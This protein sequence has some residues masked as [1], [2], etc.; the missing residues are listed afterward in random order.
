MKDQ[1]NEQINYDSGI[2]EDTGA[3]VRSVS[4]ALLAVAFSVTMDYATAVY[5]YL[6]HPV[7][8][9]QVRV[10]IMLLFSLSLF[11]AVILVKKRR[12]AIAMRIAIGWV[13]LGGL[14]HT[15]LFQN[16]GHAALLLV[17]T[18]TAAL[19]LFVFSTQNAVKLVASSAV[20]GILCLLYDFFGPSAYRLDEPSISTVSTL[21]GGALFAILFYFILINLNTLD[22]LK[23]TIEERTLALIQTNKFND[24]L[25]AEINERKKIEEELQLAKVAAEAASEAKSEFLATMSHEIRTPMNGVIG[26]TSLL[27]DTPLD[28]EQEDYVET[29]RMSGSALLGII[30]EILDF[31]KIESGNLELEYQRFD[32]YNCIEE[33]IDLLAFSASEKGLEIGYCLD[34]YVPQYIF[35]DVTRLRQILVNLIGNAVKF[36]HKGHVLVEVK[37]EHSEEEIGSKMLHFTVE[38]TGIG[39]SENQMPRLFKSFSQVDASTSRKYGG[40]GLGLAISKQL[41]EMMGGAMWVESAGEGL[42]A[43]FHFLIEY[44]RECDQLDINPNDLQQKIAKLKNRRLLIIDD[45]YL[46]REIIGRYCKAWGMCWISVPVVSEAVSLLESGEDFDFIL[47]ASHVH[48]GEVV[49]LREWNNSGKHIP[50]LAL[51][52]IGENLETSKGAS[53]EAHL[54]KPIRISALL[55]VLTNALGNIYVSNSDASTPFPARSRETSPQMKRAVKILLAED[56]VVNQKVILR[57]LEQLGYRSDAAANGVE[58][59]EA[60][61]RQQY[62]IILMDLQ[63]PEMDGLE[64]AR[65]IRKLYSAENQPHIIALTANVATESKQAAEASGMDGFLS[66]PV[67][68]SELSCILEES[69][70]SSRLS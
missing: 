1:P 9:L 44:S 34:E 69:I 18:S 21:L 19:V 42:G 15:L 46:D 50:L 31:S 32:L 35:G 27:L 61:S 63:M 66:K 2:V 4:N 65:A 54:N 6:Q 48:P 60:M 59:M 26:M 33:A 47:V 7:W 58:V 68:I 13:W 52:T 55:D 45:A 20:I 8:Q 39:I 3:K 57:F 16:F 23:H 12:L 64:T 40:T 14:T 70:A 25:T 24:Q 67:Q 53:F 37:V 17:V 62:D 51:N 11:I 29:I 41:S 38:D 28:K 43:T 30:N 36:T 56:N 22:I 49:E 5:M 10:G